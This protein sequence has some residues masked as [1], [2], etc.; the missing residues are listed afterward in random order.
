M[1]DLEITK[2]GKEG[3]LIFDPHV[4]PSSLEAVWLNVSWKELVA[5]INVTDLWL[6]R[7]DASMLM[8]LLSR[9]PLLDPVIVIQLS[10]SNNF[11]SA[12]QQRQNTSLL[13]EFTLLKMEGDEWTLDSG[14]GFII[15]LLNQHQSIGVL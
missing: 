7:I 4:I 11:K 1:T 13:K 12:K 10:Y 15:F 14:A 5:W 9:L 2:H 8:D 3:G 6:D